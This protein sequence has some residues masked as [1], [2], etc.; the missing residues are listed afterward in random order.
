[1]LCMQQCITVHIQCLQSRYTQNLTGYCCEIAKDDTN[2][3]L[4]NC[5]A[6][7]AFKCVVSFSKRENVHS[8][9]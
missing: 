4:K 3:I 1:M 2:L 6:Y 8:H 5:G 7:N 9:K